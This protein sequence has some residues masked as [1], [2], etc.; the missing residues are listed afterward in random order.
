MG[1]AVAVNCHHRAW[2]SLGELYEALA[3]PQVAG[4]LPDAAVDLRL[5]VDDGGFFRDQVVTTDFREQFSK[6]FE[7]F[8][9]PVRGGIIQDLAESLCL[10]S[11]VFSETAEPGLPGALCVGFCKAANADEQQSLDQVRLA[12]RSNRAEPSTLGKADQGGGR[13]SSVPKDRFHFFDLSPERRRRL[14]GLQ[15]A[16]IGGQC[17]RDRGHFASR[18]RTAR[19]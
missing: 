9:S 4:L 14:N 3:S 15:N 12:S 2:D 18:A 10:V 5:I 11:P 1:T 7:R 6:A 16:T 8:A 13:L 19:G 17:S